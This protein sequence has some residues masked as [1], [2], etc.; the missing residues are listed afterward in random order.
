MNGELSAEERGRL[1]AQL[2]DKLGLSQDDL[3]EQLG[4]DG[5]TVA[6]WERGA[7]QI[8]SRNLVAL[9]DALGVPQ[10]TLRTGVLPQP[11]P[12]EVSERDLK[13]VD[14]VAWLAETSGEPFEDIYQ[15]VSSGIDRL[16]SESKATRYQRDHSRAQITRLDLAQAVADY[17][18]VP[19]GD[20]KLYRAN[21]AGKEITLSILVKDDWIGLDVDMQGEQSR[22][23]FIPDLQQTTEPMPK[24]VVDAAVA[25]L[26]D[27]EANERVLINNPLY[28]LTS[29][30]IEP[31]GLH[32]TFGMASFADYALRNGLMEMETIDALAQSPNRRL[33]G[34]SSTPVRDALVP[35][36]ESVLDLESHFCTG[37]P[38]SLFAAARP[39]SEGRP[40]DYALLVQ[41]RGK[42]VMDIPGKLSTIPKGWHQPVGEAASQARFAT[43]IL[44]ELEEELLGREDLE[45]MSDD[46]RRTADPLHAERHP[47]AMLPLLYEPDGF[48]IRGTGFGL[49]LL[50]GTYEVPCLIVIE[51]EHWWGDFGHHIAGNWETM[52][53]ES[54]STM[55]TNG[56][57]ALIHDP[58]WSNEGLFALIE[59]LRRLKAIDTVGRVVVPDIHPF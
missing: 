7:Q 29:I 44:R 50:S 16:E 36:L 38:V 58:R 24:P 27:A 10:D 13:T 54:Y 39:A 2:R 47:E 31:N 15:A 33:T 46:A 23:T 55:D 3:G 20:H 48:Q 59:G 43:T 19:S 6:R 26:A 14:M 22:S 9:A 4:V 40:A 56:L 8:R 32:P 5:G 35:S 52:S 49:N 57:A 28:R 41:V 18:D 37:G 53:I 45:Q 34:Q 25:R 11:R 17:Y 12:V 42:H 30:D 1:I 21:V 51:D